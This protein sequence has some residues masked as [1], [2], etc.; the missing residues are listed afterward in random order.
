MLVQKDLHRH[1]V[2]A[3]FLKIQSVD[4]N[5]EKALECENV[6]VVCEAYIALTASSDCLYLIFGWWLILRAAFNF[7]VAYSIIIL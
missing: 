2:D 5:K 6:L 4:I 7:P 3:L 1:M